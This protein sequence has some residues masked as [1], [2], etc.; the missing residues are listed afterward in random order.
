VA[1]RSFEL[2]LQGPIDFAASLEI[3]RRSGDDL[4]DRWD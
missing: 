3:F 1:L 2:P 4:L